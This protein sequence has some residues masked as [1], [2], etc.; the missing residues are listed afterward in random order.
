MALGLEGSEEGTHMGA[1]DF[2]VGGHIFATLASIEHGF[3]NLMFT[4]DVQAE[5]LVEQGT[6]P[7]V[8]T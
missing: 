1:V 7:E 4:P 3:G 2:R 6:E 5:Y 8:A